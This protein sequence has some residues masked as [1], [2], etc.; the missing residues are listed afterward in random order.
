MREKEGTSAAKTSTK[1]KKKK[2]KKRRGG[3]DRGEEPSAEIF[4]GSLVTL[5]DRREKSDE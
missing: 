3:G 5:L 1:K 2:K 4:L